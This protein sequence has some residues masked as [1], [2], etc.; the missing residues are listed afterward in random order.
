MEGAGGPG[1]A[2]LIAPWVGEAQAEDPP[3]HHDSA[4]WLSTAQQG[5]CPRQ[6]PLARGA[7]HLKCDPCGRGAGLC[8]VLQLTLELWG[9]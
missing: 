4:H 9:V 2:C 8:I 3:L 7:E 6:A 1:P 5:S